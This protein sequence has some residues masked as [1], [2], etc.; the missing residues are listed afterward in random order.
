[1]KVKDLAERPREKALLQ[2]VQTLNDA[3]LLML[4]IESGTRKFSAFDLAHQLL[5]QCGGITYLTKLSFADL[6]S[7]PGIKEA[8]AIRILAAIELAKRISLDE[9]QEVHTITSAKDAY[10]YL[11]HHLQFEKQEHFVALYLDT[12]HHIIHYQY[13]FK[14]SL[15]CSIVHPREVFKA[16]LQISAA[17]IVVAH[18]HPSGDALPSLQDI[19]VTN[20]LYETGK[21]MQIPIIDH[22]IV[23]KRQYFS[24]NEAKML[25]EK[26]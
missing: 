3:E 10:H 7:F 12:K 13:I 17:C 11:Y 21:I 8:R 4:L 1:M 25:G 15:D 5:S 14:G 26:N 24:F 16:A 6:I 2:G 22:I 18:N 19:E 23:G 9:Q 20:L